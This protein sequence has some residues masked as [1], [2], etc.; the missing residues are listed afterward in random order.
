MILKRQNA[1][2]GIVAKRLVLKIKGKESKEIK[3]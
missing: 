1:H 2:L 3:E